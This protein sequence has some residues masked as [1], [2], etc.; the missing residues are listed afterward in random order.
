MEMTHEAA[1]EVEERG[2]GNAAEAEAAGMDNSGFVKEDSP[3]RNDGSKSGEWRRRFANC[4]LAH[5][6]SHSVDLDRHLPLSV[7][8]IDGMST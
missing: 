2:E 5:S 8:A 1:A 6:H 3:P 4:K 7:I